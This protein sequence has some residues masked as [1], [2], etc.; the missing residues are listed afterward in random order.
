E[1]KA[2]A[3]GEDETEQGRRA[4]LNFGHT[5]GHALE[6]LTSYRKYKHGEA[7]SIGMVTA[8]LIGEEM[9]ASNASVTCEIVSILQR[10][11]LPVTFPGGVD[12]D[13]LIEAMGRDKKTVDGN[14]TFIL[15]PEIGKAQVIPG[16]PLGAV[17]A[18]VRR[19]C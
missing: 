6:A 7:I 19:Q 15:I 14:L 17:R 11:G 16:T 2:A 10:A 3:V 9:G 8:A 5:V 1:I 13:E 4:I 18:A 12:V